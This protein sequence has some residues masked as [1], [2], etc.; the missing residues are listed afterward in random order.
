MWDM[1]FNRRVL[2]GRDKVRECM[3]LAK[4]LG[5][6]KVFILPYTN[7]AFGLDGIK[8]D[9]TDAGIDFVVYDKVKT[10]PDLDVIDNGASILKENGCDGVLAMGGG[11]VLDAA[12]AIAMLATNG[13]T[14]E[15]YQMDGKKIEKPCLPMIMLPTTSGTGSEATRVSVIYNP[16]NGLK[17][18]IY[19]PLMIGDAVIFDPVL[20][21]RLPPELAASTGM[22]ALSHAIEA[23]VSLNANPLTEMYSLKALNL[24]KNSLENAVENKDGGGARG[25]MML[26]SYFAGCAIHAG[27]GAAHIIAQP[28]GGMFHIPHGDACSIFLPHAMEANLEYSLQKYADIAV[29]LGVATHNLDTRAAAL[30]GIEEVLRIRECIH[31]P[32]TLRRYVQDGHFNMDHAL[33]TVTGATGHIK[34]N[35]RPVDKS[36]LRHIIEK[37]M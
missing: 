2:F 18:S 21:S 37:S 9:L 5:M 33:D 25:E 15:Q 31:A 35:P 19:S 30:A 26:A 4:E 16:H 17:K 11:S 22:D 3:P 20:V 24:I 23:Y 34:C 32:L 6:S 36:L 7:D 8:H 12:K 13:G 14:V 1:S 29:A 28:L 10:E 27:I